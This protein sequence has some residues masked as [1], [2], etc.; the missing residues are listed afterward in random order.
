M[1]LNAHLYLLS[2]LE[3]NG[4]QPVTLIHFLDVVELELF[5]YGD[6]LNIADKSIFLGM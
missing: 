3:K 1:K 6:L 4:P 2:R 5:D